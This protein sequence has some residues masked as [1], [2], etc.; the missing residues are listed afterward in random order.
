V[1][2]QLSGHT[3]DGQLFPLNLIVRQVYELSYGYKK[4]GNT[5]YFVS[6]GAGVWG[7]PVRT[8]SDCEIIEL[9]LKFK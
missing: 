5:Q 9:K 4:R 8:G 6:S 3:H 2:L 1:D 7:P